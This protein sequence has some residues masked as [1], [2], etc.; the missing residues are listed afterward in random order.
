MTADSDAFQTVQ[1]LPGLSALEQHY[2]MPVA[3]G[4]GFYGLGWG[5]PNKFT[6]EQSAKFGIDPRAGVGSNNWGAEQGQGSAG[7]FP[8]VDT[9]ADGSPYVE[10]YKRH[11]TP[12]E[13]AASVARIL[14]KPNLREALKTGVYVGKRHPELNGKQLGRLKAA[15]YT[16]H[17]N[18]YFELAPEKY[19]AAVTRNYAILTKNLGW[20]PILLD[21]PSIATAPETIAT[22]PLLVGPSGSDSQPTSSGGLSRLPKAAHEVLREGAT[23]GEVRYLQSLLPGCRVDGIFGPKTKALV[24]A[25]QKAA[26]LCPDGIV[27]PHTWIELE[28][29]NDV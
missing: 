16:Q 4:E 14:L 2:L 17:D 25:F 9:H 20:Q 21:P 23:G 24:I 22:L 27:G 11:R 26:S 7:S 12:A 6:V 18:R 19:L 1:Q 15:V 28:E 8:H 3:R 29:G 5:N 13:G 10:Q